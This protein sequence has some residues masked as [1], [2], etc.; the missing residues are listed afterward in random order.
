MA[1]I[2]A[3]IRVEDERGEVTEYQVY[4]STFDKET[5]DTKPEFR[6]EPPDLQ[7]GDYV[8]CFGAVINKQQKA[9]V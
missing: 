1:K 8:R 6:L 4:L 5:F 2:T 3:T 7:I 9:G